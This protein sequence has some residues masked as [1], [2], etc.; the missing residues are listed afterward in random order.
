MGSDGRGVG[1]V[2]EDRV[3][4]RDSLALEDIPPAAT[5]KRTAPV[6]DWATD[7]DVLDP[8]YVADPF[9]VWA[10]LR[11]RCPIAHSA[12]RG[13]D[14]LPTRY[15]DVTALAH[16][17]E[18]FSSLDVIVIPLEIDR[19]D[20]SVLP[21]GFPPISAD[22]P[23]HTWTRRLIL[24]WFSHGRVAEYEDLT[25][26]LCRTLID[27]FVAHG[28]ADAAADY[29]QQ[30]PV[31]IIAHILGVQP[32]MA[33]TFTGWVRDV[34]EFA[35][36]MDGRVRAI[37]ALIEYFVSQIEDRRAHPGDDLLSYLL[38]AD[39]DGAPV[40]EGIVLGVAA[41]L[42]IAGVDTTWSAIG[43]S[44]WHLATHH[45]DRDRLVDDPD[46]MPTAIEEM[47]R[48]YAP[49]TMA[50]VVTSDVEFGG[51]PMKA[52]D[53]ILMNFPAA[54]RD[55]DVFENADT[56]V[57]DRAVNRHVAF[58]SG[59]HRC[60]GSNLARMELRVALEEWLRQIPRFH[61]A[62]GADI[63]WAGGQVR[64]PRVLPVVFP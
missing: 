55:P 13:S 56:V 15:D 16:D 12:R 25:R 62:D 3:G 2:P 38:Q 28:A 34:L 9:G 42:L 30:I 41:L 33:D 1:I 20:E 22:P 40:E 24:P 14:W 29:A 11:Q 45:D 36:D 37:E 23:L 31:R 7:F 61:L 52:G 64:G 18:H 44:L 35:D 5:T 46:L 19:S 63:T 51:C 8:A 60:A 27:G 50:R 10:E 17:T 54:N 26:H 59:I 6:R 47:L 32:D 53:K 57:L 48:A 39:M 43:S 21:Y 49:V 58:G 4:P